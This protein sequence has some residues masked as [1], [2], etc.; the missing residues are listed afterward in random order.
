MTYNAQL[1]ATK[2]IREA[3]ANLREKGQ[4]VTIKY[5]GSKYIIHCYSVFQDEVYLV[6]RTKNGMLD[7]SMNVHSDK[8]S[9]LSITLYSFDMMKTRTDYKMKFID[10]EIV[11]GE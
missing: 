7:E 5:R 2:S 1:K 9:N 3:I 8:T 11:E 10:M 4:E 6:V